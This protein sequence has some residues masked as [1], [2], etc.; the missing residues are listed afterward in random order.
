MIANYADFDRSTWIARLGT[1]SQDLA[2]SRIGVTVRDLPDTLRIAFAT[3]G[4]L[5]QLD[6]NS[7]LGL[8]LD[9]E[10][11]GDY[12]VGVLFHSGLYSSARQAPVPWGTGRPADQVVELESLA[13]FLLSPG[14]YAPR[15]WSGRVMLTFLMQNT[16]ARTRA[17]ATVRSH[18]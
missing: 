5:Q 13:D 7:L 17:R 11:D 12:S 8:R 9:Y 3:D 18:T 10:S 1:G 14:R 15:G 6:A 16:G 4:A 2:D